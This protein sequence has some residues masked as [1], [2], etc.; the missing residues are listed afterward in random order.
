MAQLPILTLSDVCLSLGGKPL[1]EGV[2]LTLARGERAALVG[3]NGAGKSTLMR[4]ING[5][6]DPDSGE[7]W[8]QPG[9]QTTAI[10]QEPDLSCFR[11]VL[12]FATARGADVWRAEAELAEFGVSPEAA[13]KTLSGGQTRRAALARAFAEDPDILLLDEPTNHLDITMIERLEQRLTQFGGAV[14]LVSHDR[15]F[16]ESITTNTLWLRDG[17]VL[18]SSRGYGDFDRWAGEIERA[19]EQQLAKMKTQLKAE[20]HWLARG[21]TARRKRNMG[22]LSRLKDMRA[23]HARRQAA[24]MTAHNTADLDVQLGSS[25]SRKVLESHGMTKAF[26]DT[27]VVCDLN[28]KVLRGDRIGIIG[29]NGAGKSTLIRLLFGDIEPDRGTVKRNSALKVTYLDQTRSTLSG[30]E[31]LWDAL[32]PNGGDSLTV[33]GK[34]RHVAAYA[35]DFLFKAEQLRQPVSALSGGERN[36]L[37]LA[38]ALATATDVLVL[39]EPTND[40]DIQTLDLLEEM[41]LGFSGTLLLVSHDRAFLDAT[42]TSCLVP[43]GKGQWVRTAGGWSDSRTQVTSSAVPAETPAPRSGKPKS[44]LRPPRSPNKLSFKDVHRL[45]EV[46]AIIPKLEQKIDALE[47]ALADADLYQRDPGAFRELSQDLQDTKDQLDQAE[48]DWLEIEEKRTAL[49]G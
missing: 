31:T 18:K 13:P 1:F 41:L 10:A 23:E 27:P 30:V 42:V 3:R 17:A 15:Y 9:V 44:Q 5:Q 26:S 33:Q 48:E 20:Q 11:S 21:V 43:V 39:D 49:N 34:S 4:I 46:E 6:T 36:R 29:P 7:V 16:M 2:T 45:K 14:L 28:L 40:L 47:L 12:E 32:A 38:I 24:L 35:K 8:L 19:E 22:R 37:T 25:Q